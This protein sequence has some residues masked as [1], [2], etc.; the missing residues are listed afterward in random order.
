MKHDV[1]PVHVWVHCPPT[2]VSEQVVPEPQLYLQLPV[3]HV[4]VQLVPCGQSH[5]PAS[6]TN[7]GVGPVSG[8]SAASFVPPSSEGDSEL[9]AMSAI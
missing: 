3:W 6:Q 7:V 5:T 9:H 1:A 2:H 8:S 4:S